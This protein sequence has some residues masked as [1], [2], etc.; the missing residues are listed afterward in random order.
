MGFVVEVRAAVKGTYQRRG[1]K[2]ARD[3]P[4]KKNESPPGLPRMRRLSSAERTRIDAK[5]YEYLAPD[6]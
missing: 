4:Y 3:W 1:C 5:I 6:S 2:R